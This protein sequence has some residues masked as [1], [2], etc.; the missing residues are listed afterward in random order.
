[1]VGFTDVGDSLVRSLE[2][3]QLAAMAIASFLRSADV[4]LAS[5]QMSLGGD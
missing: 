4:L 1:M 3:H 5:A 2:A